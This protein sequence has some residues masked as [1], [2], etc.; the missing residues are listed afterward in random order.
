MHDAVIVG[1]GPAGATTALLLA[2]AGARV[3]LLDRHPFPRPKPCG[4]CLSAAATTLL[5]DLGLLD[6]VLA[7]PHARLRGWRIVAPNGHDFRADFHDA[8]C[9]D[10]IA[11]ERSALDAALLQCARAAGADFREGAHVTDLCRD[12][13]GRVIGVRLRDGTTFHAP[14]TVAADGLRSVVATRLGAV[15]RPPVIRKMSFTFHLDEPCETGRFG[16]MHVARGL[17][18]GIAPVRHDAGRTNVT[19]VVDARVHGPLDARAAVRLALDHLPALHVRLDAFHH[20]TCHASGPFDRPVSRVVFDGAALVGDAA[21]YFD[22][23]TG[24]GIFQ[25]LTDA[26]GLA[27]VALAALERDD[28]SAQALLPYALRR[29]RE[30]RG[31][32]AFQRVV[33]AALARPSLAD[34]AIS[35]VRASPRLANAVLA[36]TGDLLRPLSLRGLAGLATRPVRASGAARTDARMRHFTRGGHGTGPPPDR[37]LKP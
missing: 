24:Q 19:V 11:V 34:P 32:R 8:G 17:C 4:D 21:G 10:A 22:P 16:E 25:A 13:S 7:L 18:A 23:F 26:V 31:I 6:A 36:V 28:V 3:V 5:T 37:E 33:D 9:A 12:P 29:R 20:A 1:A 2:R 14:L 15:A 30:A 27:P 35:V